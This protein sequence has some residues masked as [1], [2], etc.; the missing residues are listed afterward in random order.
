MLFDILR[1]LLLLGLFFLV[2]QLVKALFFFI[3]LWQLK[4][5]RW[6]RFWAHIKTVTG[7]DQLINNLCL[8]KNKSFYYPQITIR[9]ILI[10]A[11]VLFFQYDA[12]FILL[13]LIYP[14]YDKFFPE[15]LLA[16]LISL[17]ILIWFTPLLVGI[18]SAISHFFLLSIKQ[19]IVYVATQKRN[20][21]K[22]LLVIG[23]TGSYGKTS[24]K[25]LVSYVLG[26][27]F[28]VLATPLN[29]NTREGIAAFIIRKL[30]ASHQIFVVEMGAYKKGEISPIC[31]MVKPQ[32]GII[33]GINEQHLSLFKNLRN[34]REAKTELIKAL[35]KNGLALF[36]ANNRISLQMFRETRINKLLY[37]HEKTAYRT[38]L[39]GNWYQEPI[40]AALL[41]GE[42]LGLNKER[43]VKRLKRVEVLPLGIKIK[44]GKGR[45]RVIDDSYNSNPKGFSSALDLM[46]QFKAK[47]K[48]LIT[49]GII[50]LGSAAAKIHQQLGQKA[51]GICQQIYLTKKDWLKPISWGVK[52]AKTETAIEVVEDWSE[53]KG[54]L[55]AFLKRDCLILLEGRV[56]VKIKKDILSI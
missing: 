38:K 22:D 40:Q 26:A 28:K 53:L 36:N 51:A 25:E 54:K 19:F 17:G 5:Y 50:E 27:N 56:S 1:F 24:T 11:L 13:R 15:V 47:K 43:M 14:I 20:K 9:V 48:I 10:L 12:L 34:T 46:T 45:V 16:F 35:P 49:P 29:C 33:T 23:I 32:V 8:W 30:K 6:D 31:R 21:R 7:R 55:K 4:E 3:Y 42:Y 39:V 41:V 2:I 52:K 37:G 18:S 44:R